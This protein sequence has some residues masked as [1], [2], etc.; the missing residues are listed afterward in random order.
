MVVIPISIVK[1]CTLLKVL[2]DPGS[3]STLVSRKCLPRHCKM[4]PIKQECKIDTLAGSYE[5]KEVVVMRNLM[6]P[7]LDKNCVVDQQKSISV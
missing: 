2:F 1:P 3:T 5:T 4:C 6:L 7:E